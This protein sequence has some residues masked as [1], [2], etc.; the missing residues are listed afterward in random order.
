MSFELPMPKP[1]AIA[2]SAATPAPIRRDTPG[3]SVTPSAGL[4]KKQAL[5]IR[6]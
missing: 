3:D 4:P 2:S 5:A 1:I 6:R